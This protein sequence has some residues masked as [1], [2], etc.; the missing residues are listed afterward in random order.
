MIPAGE[1]NGRPVRSDVARTNG[2]NRPATRGGFA[3]V[4]T[5]FSNST[6][7]SGNAIVAGR[8][9]VADV[10]TGRAM[11]PVGGGSSRPIVV[12]YSSGAEGA[13]AGG[14]HSIIREARTR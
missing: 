11:Y 5:R 9:S 12:R 8:T 1:L 6:S 7:N 14:M 10:H 13:P 4:T 3:A 2:S